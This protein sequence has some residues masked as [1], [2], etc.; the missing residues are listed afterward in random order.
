M[1]RK[2][3]DKVPVTPERLKL[4]K[5][6]RTFLKNNNMIEWKEIKP[7]GFSVNIGTIPQHLASQFLA[8]CYQTETKTE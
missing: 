6:M 4:Q 8:I 3:M 7:L 2:A 1:P 5:D